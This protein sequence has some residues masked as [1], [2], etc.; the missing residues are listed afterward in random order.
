VAPATTQAPVTTVA[1]ATTVSLPQPEVTVPQVPQVQDV[2]QIVTTLPGVE[3]P[4]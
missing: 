4:A 3:L 1:P 2:P